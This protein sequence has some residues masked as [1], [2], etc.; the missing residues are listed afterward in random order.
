MLN[1][2]SLKL[3]IAGDVFPVES[4]RELFKAGD[5]EALFGKKVVQ[6][7]AEAD[8][9]VCNP[10]GCMADHPEKISKVGP[11]VTAS[12]SCLS[13]LQKLGIHAV[14]LGNTH[15]MDGGP[16]GYR[17]YT[18][19]LNQL[20]IVHFGS[21]S[22]LSHM[23]TH[24]RIE[25]KGVRVI[26]YNVTEFFFNGATETS[27]G[28]HIYDEAPILAE[29]RELKKE[30]D[31]LVVLY[32]GGAES[33][34]Y[35]TPLIRE[36]FHRMADAGADI[37]ISQHTHAI[38]EEERYKDSLLIYGQ[39]N[40]CFNLARKNNEHLAHGMLL[41]FAFSKDG[42]ELEKHVVRRT[43]IGCEYEDDPDLSGYVERSKL[44]DLL[45]EGNR[46]ATEIFLRENRKISRH[47]ITRFMQGFYGTTELPQYNKK[48]LQIILTLLQSDEMR[49]MAICYFTDLLDQMDRTIEKKR[50]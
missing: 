6:L 24:I 15:T 30:C 8:Y 41:S 12:T 48:Q 44:H 10:E 11:T 23:K 46:D 14:T 50:R 34:F 33:T 21:G 18:E 35:N 1:S 36:R 19:A 4:N 9:S 28:A 32:H 25:E 5:T 29:L 37:L 43:E 13:A 27:P 31:H 16:T 20:G 7:F 49:E 40:F 42:Y 22:D 47:F 17:E 2:E 39:G 38:G 3:L 45:L 26:L